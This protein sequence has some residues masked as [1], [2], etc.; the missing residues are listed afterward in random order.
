M[1]A[2]HAR[3]PASDFDDAMTA[4]HSAAVPS[5][6]PTT[7]GIVVAVV[8]VALIVVLIAVVYHHGSE[9]EVSE[10]AVF[11]PY[12]GSQTAVADHPRKGVLA[13]PHGKGVSALSRELYPGMHSN[14]QALQSSDLAATAT[15]SDIKRISELHNELATLETRDATDMQELVSVIREAEGRIAVLQSQLA[16]LRQLKQQLPDLEKKMMM[17]KEKEQAVEAKIHALEEA[18]VDSES[19]IPL[20]TSSSPSS[21]SSPSQHA[22]SSEKLSQNSLTPKVERLQSKLGD[23]RKVAQSRSKPNSKSNSNLKR[24]TSS[25]YRH[26]TAMSEDDLVRNEQSKRSV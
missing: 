16:T 12:P 13:K 2:H 10:V 23:A 19:F 9:V 6:S 22:A 8:V 24:L 25:V 7:I 15:L 14:A 1:D 3:Y 4:S 18:M 11:N 5:V 26:P 17:D 20:P 21:S